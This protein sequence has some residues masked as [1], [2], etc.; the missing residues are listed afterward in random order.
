[1]DSVDFSFY[2]PLDNKVAESVLLERGFDYFLDTTREAE[3]LGFKVAFVPDHIMLPN[4]DAPLE[5]WTAL[6]TMAAKTNKIHLS[7][8]VTPIPLY[9]P[10]F[11]AKRVTM[12]DNISQGRV[13]LGVGCGWY[14]RE[15]SAFGIQFD[16]FQ[17]RVQKMVEGIEIIRALWTMNQPV[18]YKGRY[19]SLKEAVLLP[20]PTQK[21][22][23][24][25]WFGGLSGH[26]LDATAKYGQGWV[27][28]EAPPSIFEEKLSMIRK[29]TQLAKRDPDDIVPAIAF[30]T[31]ISTDFEEVKRQMKLL[32]I[33]KRFV[34]PIIGVE[35][36]TVCGTP[37]MC[38]DEINEYVK[39]GARH[40]IIGIQPTV[41]T[42][43]GLQLYSEE[44]IPHIDVPLL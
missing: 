18:T 29:F 34:H 32:S 19:Y 42:F 17:V 31:V 22:H 5:A 9:S 6:T 27:P 26:I 35:R 36:R 15:F 14:K 23:P 37:E 25:I 12:L 43:E 39:A 24:P 11:L 20:K 7:S 41:E 30:R 40:V 16:Q 13:I 38:I 10:A 4:N 21:P 3:K 2:F 1:M 28:Y 44:V 8:L 33:E